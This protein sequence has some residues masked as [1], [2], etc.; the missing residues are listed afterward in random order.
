MKDKHDIDYSEFEK[1]VNQQILKME[2]PTEKQMNIKISL[3][4]WK[5]K[6]VKQFITTAGIID[7]MNKKIKG[8]QFSSTCEGCGAK[9][10]ASL[11]WTEHDWDMA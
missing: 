4:C 5:C 2:S 6:S 11:D 10:G 9:I 1:G 3:I 7:L 8:T